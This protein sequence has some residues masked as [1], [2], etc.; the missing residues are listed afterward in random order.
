[1]VD[2]VTYVIVKRLQSDQKGT[3]SFASDQV[4]LFESHHYHT[5]CRLLE[6]H[7]NKTELDAHDKQVRS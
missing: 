7:A 1:M 6:E 5:Y 2:I 3:L 4:S